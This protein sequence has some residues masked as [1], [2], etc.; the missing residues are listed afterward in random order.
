MI[1]LDIKISELRGLIKNLKPNCA[2]G[3]DKIPNIALKHLNRRPLIHLLNIYKYCFK[4]NYFPEKW[5]TPKVM[6]P[7]P[8]K[9]QSIPNNL[10]PICLLPSLSKMLE[11]LILEKL[12]KEILENI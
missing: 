11:K 9:D 3:T 7:K 12:K 6:L 5:K 10:R 4:Y 8:G 2:P 1:M